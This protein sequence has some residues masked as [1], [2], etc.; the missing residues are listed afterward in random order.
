MEAVEKVVNNLRDD[1]REERWR[2]FLIAAIFYAVL[3]AFF[4]SLLAQDM[5]QGLL[6]GAGW[7]GYLGILGLKR[8]YAE[9]ASEKDNALERS[10]DT[11]QELR[12]LMESQQQAIERIQEKPAETG[13]Q[14]L[15]DLTTLG[16]VETAR[17][18]P[19][20]GEIIARSR[21]ARAL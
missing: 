21:N 9:R 19:E 17:H 10:E 16:V 1:L 6:I 15:L 7:T 3:G 13:E 14:P 5:L 4:A 11:L 2:Q 8:D 20:V 18:L 12:Q